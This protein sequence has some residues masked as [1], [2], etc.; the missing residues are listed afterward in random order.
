MMVQQDHIDEMFKKVSCTFNIEE[1]ERC[2]VPYPTEEPSD[3]IAPRL[4]KFET[5]AWSELP[6]HT[7]WLPGVKTEISAWQRAVEACSAKCESVLRSLRSECR[8]V[9]SIESE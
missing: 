3:A 6:H 8:C 4:P 7:L 2:Y 1:P 9:S 5:I